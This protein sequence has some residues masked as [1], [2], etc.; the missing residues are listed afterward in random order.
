MTY[1]GGITFWKAGTIVVFSLWTNGLYQLILNFHQTR[2]PQ[3]VVQPFWAIPGLHYVGVMS[4]FCH[5]FSILELVPIV[6]AASVGGMFGQSNRSILKCNN[7]S[8]SVL[9]N[10]SSKNSHLMRLL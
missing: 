9:Q 7:S 10:K 6:L 8:V 3:T 4:L 5:I 1:N 2:Q